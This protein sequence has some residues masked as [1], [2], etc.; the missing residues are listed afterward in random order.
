M[1]R[2]IDT[3]DQSFLIVNAYKKILIAE[4]AHNYF[5]RAQ[6]IEQRAHE[7]VESQE[8]LS[9]KSVRSFLYTYTA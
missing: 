3:F 9:H 7:Y 6:T 1:F 8:L 4:L 5:D 2:K